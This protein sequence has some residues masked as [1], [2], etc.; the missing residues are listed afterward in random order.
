[1]PNWHDNKQPI[2]P[3]C[4]QNFNFG[5]RIGKRKHSTSQ[6]ADVPPIKTINDR[7]IINAS[8][9]NSQKKNTVSLL[10][11]FIAFANF[12]RF[13]SDKAIARFSR[14]LFQ[15]EVLNESCNMKNE[16][17]HIESDTNT[18]MA[19]HSNNKGIKSKRKPDE[20]F[21]AKS[22]HRHC[23][24]CNNSQ[25]ETDCFEFLLTC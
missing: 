21:H 23:E 25:K 8:K 22:V 5:N 1:M 10:Y 4:N 13:E 15:S 16:R 24:K 12:G 2:L 11:N 17:K 9:K 14:V 7:N 6:K 18:Q 19:C 3:R 20:A